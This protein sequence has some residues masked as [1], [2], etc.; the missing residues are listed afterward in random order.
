[1][2]LTPALARLAAETLDDVF[3][4]EGDAVVIAELTPDA[5]AAY[6]TGQHHHRWF[7]VGALTASSG[8]LRNAEQS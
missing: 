6:V 8:L 7:K 5:T 4:P 3:T 1:M 2:T